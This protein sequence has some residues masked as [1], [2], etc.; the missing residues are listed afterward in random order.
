MD[1][2]MFVLSMCRSVKVTMCHLYCTLEVGTSI[3]LWSYPKW[4][5]K[6]SQEQTTQLGHKVSVLTV[7]VVARADP[8]M[9]SK[10]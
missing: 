10:S 6:C 8:K 5:S 9:G 3:N 4:T 1:I 2:Q 7:L